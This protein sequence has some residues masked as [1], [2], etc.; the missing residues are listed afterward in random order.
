MSLV[1]DRKPVYAVVVPDGN[2][3]VAMSAATMPVDTVE[4]AQPLKRVLRKGPK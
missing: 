3:A 2:D 1:Q 4:K